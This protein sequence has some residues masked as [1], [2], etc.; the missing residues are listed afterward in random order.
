MVNRGRQR[1]IKAKKGRRGGE[2]RE[3]DDRGLNDGGMKGSGGQQVLEETAV[4]LA[5]QLSWRPDSANK[6]GVERRD[7]EKEEERGNNRGM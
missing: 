5:T 4:A 6:G 3:G 7:E 1:A 2:G